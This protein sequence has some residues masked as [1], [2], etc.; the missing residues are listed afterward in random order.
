MVDLFITSIQNQ[1][2]LNA[3]WGFGLSFILTLGLTPVV[4][5]LAW[6]LGIIDDPKKHK[7]VKVI[8]TY[9]VPRG[10]GIAL[11]AGVV[12]AASYFLPMDKH[13]LGILIGAAVVVGVGIADDKIGLNPY[14]RLFLNF[15]CASI[16]VAA[17]IGIAF[18]SNPLGGTI[19]LDQPRILVDLLGKV[20]QIWILAD[21]FAILWIVFLMN[22]VSWSSGVDG[23]LSGVV[24]IAAVV[25]GLLSLRFSADVTQWSVLILAFIV[26]G[27]YLGF[28]PYH[29]FPQKIMPGYSGATLAGFLLAV[30][31]IL[32][33]TKVGTLMVVLG[34]PILDGIYTIGRRIVSGRSPVWGD[35]GHLHHKLLDMG[36][37]K[38][39]VAVIYWLIT[40]ALGVTA[41][42][43]N[44]EQKLYTIIMI[45]T[46]MGGFLLWVN[47]FTASSRRPGP[48]NG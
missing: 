5:K 3:L 2:V 12:T 24:A 23:Q 8:H 33:T 27:A 48:G 19:Y 44:A 32:S 28:L 43:L 11:L 38:R 16:V 42:Y 34:V 7:H 21:I 15:V 41:L 25:I 47:Y 45:A 29:I 37:S 36:I 39:Y 35:R 13:L 30:L 20:R 46:I 26:G 4:I 14:L 18:L 9:S 10:G 6:R 22:I 17:G 1:A 31:S 40:L